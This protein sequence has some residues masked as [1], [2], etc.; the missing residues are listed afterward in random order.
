MTATPTANGQRTT[1]Q[2]I[3]SRGNP[4][5]SPKIETKVGPELFCPPT[6]AFEPTA[7]KQELARME[8]ARRAQLDLP[9]WAQELREWWTATTDDDISGSL[10]KVVEYGGS[11]A[12]YDLISTGRRLARLSG[13]EVGDEEAVE[14]GIAFYISSKLDRWMAAIMDGR[15]PS[16]DT[17]LDVVY[18]GMMARRNRAVGGWPVK[19]A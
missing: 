10:S 8:L 11:G 13:R 4:V 17:L 5:G 16:D 19:P 12:A 2:P 9:D 14:L 1:T 15:R 6:A 3:D 7:S 18:Y